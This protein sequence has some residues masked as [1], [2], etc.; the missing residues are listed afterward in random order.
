[1]VGVKRGKESETVGPKIN[2]VGQKRR[3]WG[4]L[5]KGK[6]KMKI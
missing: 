6:E 2:R 4:V 1:M 5:G 3:E